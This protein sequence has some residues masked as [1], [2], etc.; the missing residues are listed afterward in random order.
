MLRRSTLSVNKLFLAEPGSCIT[1]NTFIEP[2][3]CLTS[4]FEDIF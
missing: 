2:R 3:Q 1:I 4:E